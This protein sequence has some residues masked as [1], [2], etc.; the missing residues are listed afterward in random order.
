[1]TSPTLTA[2]TIDE[3]LNSSEW[4]GF[5]LEEGI[6]V[7]VPISSFSS[8]V[9]GRAYF[10]LESAARIHGGTTFPQDSALQCW[11]D[12]PRHFRKP[13]AMYFQP[14]VLSWP[15]PP[16]PTVAP[17][18]V[19]E[20]ISPTEIGT[21]IEAK[22]REYLQAGVRLLWV[23]YPET[24]TVYVLRADETV[25][26]LGPGGTLTGEDVL[27]GLSI[28]VNDLFRLPENG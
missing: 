21:R 18:I 15:L 1:M 19:V 2:P 5:E 3:Y 10:Y 7:E 9:G 20:V 12:R 27:P 4:D 22:N 13:D 25:T 23:I 6:P 17:G 16:V 11:P 26:L 24:Q 28:A 8:W 14:G